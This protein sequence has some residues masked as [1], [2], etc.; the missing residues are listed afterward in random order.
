MNV[1][2]ET[3]GALTQEAV[4][5]V[6]S[7]GNIKVEET[8]YAFLK[9][10]IP[11]GITRIAFIDRTPLQR[12]LHNLLIIFVS[13]GGV[14]LVVLFFI[15][16]YFANR[17]VA[18]IK[19]VFEKQRQFIADASHELKTPLAVIK[20]NASLVLSN[21]EEVVSSQVK[22]LE[23]ILFQADRMTRLLEEMLSL[24]RLDYSD[25]KTEIKKVHSSFDL[26]DAV[27]GS[28]LSFEGFMYEKSIAFETSITPGINFTG[29]KESI[30]RLVD[31]LL[32][33]AVK[34][35][36]EGGKVFLSLNTE[37]DRVELR[38]SNTGE[39]IPPEHLD[40]IF[41]RF[42]RI[43]ASRSK[44]TGGYGLG[45]SIA[46]ATVEQHNGRISVRSNP[47]IDTTFAVELPLKKAEMIRIPEDF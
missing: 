34:H 28:A 46:K 27:R 32:D 9:R 31:I 43:D 22:W 41:E 44:E 17:T 2:S 20:T 23:Y 45:L 29:D 33:N 24:S 16:L 4:N 7:S 36:Q 13:V 18:P 8:Y 47:G 39:G 42:Y 21:Q 11:E 37:E 1:N 30:K 35:S 15:S 5:V 14:S 12:T 40:R 25:S 38:V 3:I 6:G 26:S 10:Q 19:E